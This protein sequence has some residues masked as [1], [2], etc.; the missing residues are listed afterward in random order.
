MK[1]ILL[2]EL[3]EDDPNLGALYQEELGDA[4]YHT[5]RAAS[6]REAIARM[7]GHR[8]DPVVLDINMSG[9]DGIEEMEAMLEEQPHLP[10]IINSGHDSYKDSFRLGS[11]AYVVKSSDLSELKAQIQCVLLAQ[12]PQGNA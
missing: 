6:G 9:M 11:A 3:I 12:Q 7:M 1:T 8:L 5:L 10:V 4:G 2:I